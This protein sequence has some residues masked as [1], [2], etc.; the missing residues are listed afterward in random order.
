MEERVGRLR[1]KLRE[2]EG[3][4]WFHHARD[5]HKTGILHGSALTI[6]GTILTTVSVICKDSMTLMAI[7]VGIAIIGVVGIWFYW[8]EL[9]AMNRVHCR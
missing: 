1:A 8:G 5:Y 2:I 9:A 7:G 4:V 3:P 6:A